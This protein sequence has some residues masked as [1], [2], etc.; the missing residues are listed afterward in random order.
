MSE[1]KKSVQTVT[2][3]ESGATLMSGKGVSAVQQHIQKQFENARSLGPTLKQ[4]HD[5]AQDYV[6][7]LASD[8][9]SEGFE[10]VEDEK[11][12]VAPL[13]EQAAMK[14]VLEHLSTI[15]MIGNK[16]SASTW[17]EESHIGTADAEAVEDLYEKA[18]IAL[19]FKS[20]EP[21]EE[22]IIPA[23]APEKKRRFW[24]KK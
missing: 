5:V 11:K 22:V 6:E 3:S 8:H 21:A 23:S 1:E 7:R 18:D 10:V 15:K 9:V 16:K 24:R 4:I 2:R 14:R 19:G 13:S 20:V 12:P 17:I